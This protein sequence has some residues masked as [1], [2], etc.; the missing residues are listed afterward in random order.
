MLN[1]Y[2]VPTHFL[3]KQHDISG[4]TFATKNMPHIK[5]AL[6][7]LSSSI[8]HVLIIPKYSSIDRFQLKSVR[9]YMYKKCYCEEMKNPIK[10]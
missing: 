6:L 4:H 1:V 2:N 7:T 5:L 9:T 8:A 10:L 3:L